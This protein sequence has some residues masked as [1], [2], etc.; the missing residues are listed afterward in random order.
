LKINIPYVFKTKLLKHHSMKTY[1]GVEAR[2]HT[3]LTLALMEMSAQLFSPASLTPFPLDMRLDWPQS[4]S[5]CAERLISIYRKIY[6][7]YNFTSFYNIVMKLC[8]PNGRIY[9]CSLQM[10]GESTL[11]GA[12]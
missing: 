6:V 4:W 5:G 2:L 9:A 10:D 12:S 11:L 3:F 1:G 7:N 8:Q